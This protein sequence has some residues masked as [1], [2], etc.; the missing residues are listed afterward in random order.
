MDRVHNLLDGAGLSDYAQRF[1]EWSYDSLDVLLKMGFEDLQ[2]LAQETGM[3]SEDVQQ[4]GLHIA[5]VNFGAPMPPI[6]PMPTT[7]PTTAS[8]A[9]PQTVSIITTASTAGPQT[10]GV[11]IIPT[12]S[13]AGPQTAGVP[14]ITT[15][16]TA[17]QTF[18]S[19]FKFKESYPTAH[20]VKLC[21][22]RHSTQLGCSAML[23]HKKSGSRC[24]IYRCRS[25][26][27]T[28]LRKEVENEG[29]DL[30]PCA[31]VLHWTKKQEMWHLHPKKSDP[32]HAP[33]CGSLQHVTKFQLTHDPAF[34]KTVSIDKTSTGKGAA[35]QALG[36]KRQRLA[37]S[38]KSHT[39][40]RARNDINRFSTKDYNEDWSKLGQ[41]GVEWMRLNP[42]SR[43][44]LLTD[45][46]ERLDVTVVPRL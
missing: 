4:L 8:T 10:A 45:E 3:S 28:K 44:E 22:L 14:I 43:F 17:E 12:A 16:S 24:K 34:V 1:Y 15:A 39:A 33:F 38:V 9:G 30:A 32:K 31:Y 40:R 13:T 46:E 21:S 29:G 25:E 37:G 18:E 42:G 11:P 26:L 23:D 20:D 27:S 5:N 6:P 35:K 41:W 36:G 7:T 2:Q 19:R